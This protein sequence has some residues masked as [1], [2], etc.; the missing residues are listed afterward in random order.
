MNAKQKI[1]NVPPEESHK[2][3]TKL[4]P[5]RFIIYENNDRTRGFEVFDISSVSPDKPFAEVHII[6][7]KAVQV[8]ITKEARIKASNDFEFGGF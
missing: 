4:Y 1:R 5:L 2:M 7:G 6:E 3:L 8:N